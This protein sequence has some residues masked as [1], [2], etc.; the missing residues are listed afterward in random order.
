MSTCTPLNRR[1]ILKSF[2]MGMIAAPALI[3][4][5]RQTD[6]QIETVTHSYQD[7]RYRAPYM[8]G[9][10][11]V[12]RVT[13]LNVTCTVRTPDGRRAKGF[14]SM[15]MG[16]IWAFPS[17]TMSYDQTLNA[18]KTLSVKIEK[19]TNDYKEYGHPIDINVALEPAYLKAA[20]ETTAEQK[21][22]EAIPKLCTL[23]TASPFDA[24]I[25][26]AFGK[27]HNRNTYLTYGPD[28]LPNDLSRYLGADYKGLWL[29]QF[30]STKPRASLSLFHS[31]GA[32]DPLTSAENKHPIDDGLPE[33]LSEWI[34]H[35][36]V[37]H[38]K[39]KLNGDDLA[40]D[41]SRVL[42]IDQVNTE[43]QAKRGVDKWFYSLDFN[44][45]C[46]NVDYLL[47]FIHRVKERRPLAFSRI[48]YV[49]QPTA[50]DLKANRQNVMHKASALVPV[51]ID[52]SLTGL[53]ALMLARDMGYTGAALK[54]CKGQTQA[55]LL[56][57]AGQKLKMYLC[58]QDLTCPGASLV[59]SAGI[60]A[61]VPGVTGIEANSRQ[62]VPAANKGWDK[63]FPGLFNIHD[64]LM[65]T[66]GLTGLG[67][68]AV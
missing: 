36:G 54:A 35:D 49:E 21:L 29:H 16:N 3:A 6:I 17:R 37:N 61:H 55:M 15:P 39:I 7:Y 9:G 25:H 27:V 41:V 47:A 63:R 45:K 31:V 64:G 48:Q 5:R 52:E 28:F 42:E 44:E 4:G 30:I 2:S 12:D 40:S 65:R 22:T 51:V 53:D 18:M 33:T 50:R 23:V 24:A 68:G 59:Q 13:L 62:Y 32:S 34:E 19:L 46:R 56:G 26:D 11:L 66:G 8:F 58:V 38:L 57:A 60:A 67:L 10:S 20:A 14:G 43:T 1:K